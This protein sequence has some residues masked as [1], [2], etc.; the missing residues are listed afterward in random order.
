MNK[1]GSQWKT[2]CLDRRFSGIDGPEVFLERISAG[3]A[4]TIPWLFHR[5]A[6]A[7]LKIVFRVVFPSTEVENAEKQRSKADH[8]LLSKCGIV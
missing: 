4:C 7:T 2:G 6:Q 3:C 8:T 5:I 1:P